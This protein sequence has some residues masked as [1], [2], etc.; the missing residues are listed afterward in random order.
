MKKKFFYSSDIS[1]KTNPK[2]KSF[3]FCAFSPE[4]NLFFFCFAHARNLFPYHSVHFFCAK[5]VDNTTMS[6]EKKNQ[7]KRKASSSLIPKAERA[8]KKNAEEVSSS[9]MQSQPQRKKAKQQPASTESK[10]VVDVDPDTGY[11]DEQKQLVQKF[12]ISKQQS[13]QQGLKYGLHIQYFLLDDANKTCQEIHDIFKNGL[14]KIV[15]ERKFGAGD[16]HAIKIKMSYYGKL[17]IEDTKIAEKSGAMF[18]LISTP[19]AKAFLSTSLLVLLANLLETN[20]C[21][22]IKF[23]FD[24]TSFV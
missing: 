14:D 4:K 22:G 15:I 11:T 9:S 18:F 23:S 1:V 7:N 20:N 8:R 6:D 3:I 10:T 19:I 13:L 17:A 5:E 12:F 24:T 21:V 2:K 16:E